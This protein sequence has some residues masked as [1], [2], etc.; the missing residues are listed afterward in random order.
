[1]PDLVFDEAQKQ[2]HQEI[3]SLRESEE[4]LTKLEA[5]LVEQLRRLRSVRHHLEAD[6]RRKEATRKA[7]WRA[8]KATTTAFGEEATATSKNGDRPL[9]NGLAIIIVI[10]GFYSRIQCCP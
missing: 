7:D 1:M 2:L 9:D 4:I 6:C 10:S 5:S 3:F 8:A